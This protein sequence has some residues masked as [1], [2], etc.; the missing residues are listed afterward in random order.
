MSRRLRERRKLQR[1]GYTVTLI[2]FLRQSDQCTMKQNETLSEGKWLAQRRFRPVLWERLKPCW[3][4]R[5]G[6]AGA[7]TAGRNC[8]LGE[9]A[10]EPC[11]RRTAGF[12]FSL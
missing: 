5:L 11:C 7:K 2:R 3:A 10:S 9:E 4:R 1:P 8:R 6:W 12:D